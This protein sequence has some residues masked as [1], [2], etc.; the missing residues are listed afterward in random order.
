MPTSIK[1][2]SEKASATKAPAHKEATALLRA[3]H[4][5][6]SDLFEQYEKSRSTSKK[7]DLVAQ[8]CKEL[9]VHAQ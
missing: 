4:K 1:T 9:T 7:K 2:A 6:V 8:I 3:D 5:L